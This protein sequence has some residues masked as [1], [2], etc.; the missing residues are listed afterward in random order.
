MNIKQERYSDYLNIPVFLLLGIVS[1]S[2]KADMLPT[3]VVSGITLQHQISIPTS[4]EYDTN[5]ALA[6]KNQIEIWRLSVS[7]RYNLNAYDGPNIWTLGA[8]LNVQRSSDQLIAQDRQDPTINASWQRE[9]ALGS[10]G[11]NASYTQSSSRISEVKSTGL[12]FSDG[13]SLSRNIGAN[14]SRSFSDNVTFSLTASYSEQTFSGQS[15]GLTNFNTQ[16]I[17][18]NLTN[19]WNEKLSTYLQGSHTNFKP[20]V[21]TSSDLISAVIGAIYK[22]S[23]KLDLNING[24][25]NQS[26]GLTTATNF[27]GGLT[28]SYNPNEN[29]R[30]TASVARSSNGSGLGRV[31]ETDSLI[32]G[33]TY[34]RN[35]FDTLGAN[36]SYNASSDVNSFE[37]QQFSLFGTRDLSL[38]WQ[39]RLSYSH[40]MSTSNNL[41]A[42]GDVIGLSLIYN[43]SSF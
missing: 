37:F 25:L 2:V 35:D 31:I 5:P 43:I 36:Y 42:D 34:N 23:E 16:S 13:T 28:A 3:G 15:S 8:A 26:S 30:Y 9:Y 19:I 12:V 24:G 32:F 18:P 4:L 20:S 7:P 22:P 1:L 41:N 29:L 38:N 33:V 6:D 17:S 21:G 14:Y 40:K 10:Y 27:Q 11:I 39:T